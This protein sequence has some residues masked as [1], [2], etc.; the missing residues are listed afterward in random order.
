MLID[1]SKLSLQTKKAQQIVCRIKTQSAW[2]TGFLVT[3]PLHRDFQLCILTNHH[4][5][6]TEQVANTAKVEFRWQDPDTNEY[7]GK[8][9]H[10]FEVRLDPASL[11]CTNEELDFTLVAIDQS[12]SFGICDPV[13][14]ASLDPAEADQVYLCGH[15]NG[16]EK[17]MYSSG[18]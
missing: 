13:R 10:P 6:D 9:D 8:K 7:L 14:L 1:V 18:T 16:S 15:P 2:G 5:I 3:W 4:I 17:Q 11:F 12:S